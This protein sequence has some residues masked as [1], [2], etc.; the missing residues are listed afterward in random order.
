MKAKFVGLCLALCFLS[1]AAHAQGGADFYDEGPDGGEPSFKDRLFFGGN[2]GLSFG[3]VTFID[4]SPTVGYRVNDKVSAGVG[5]T[6]QYLRNSRFDLETSIYGGRVFGRRTLNDFLFAQVEYET[7]N[8]EFVDPGDFS[9][10]REWVPAFF[11]GGGLYQPIG[12]NAALLITA[13]YNVLHDEVR[14]PYVDPLV[15]RVGFVF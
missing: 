14:S 11:L 5:V 13:L 2:F 10:N 3:T 4:I 1:F 8:V 9:F 6:Y 7:L 12:R 15:L